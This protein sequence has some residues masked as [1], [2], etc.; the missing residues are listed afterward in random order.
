MNLEQLKK[1]TDLYSEGY[2]SVSHSGRRH[3]DGDQTSVHS[4][5]HRFQWQSGSTHLLF[6]ILVSAMNNNSIG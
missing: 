4:S 3:R 1:L 6:P 5:L 2:K